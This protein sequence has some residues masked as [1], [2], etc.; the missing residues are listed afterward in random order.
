MVL[1]TFASLSLLLMA[2]AMVV[3]AVVL[4]ARKSASKHMHAYRLAIILPLGVVHLW[5]AA[6]WSF[7]LRDAGALYYGETGGLV[8]AVLASLTDA[9]LG[10]RHVAVLVVV[11]VG[12][13]ASLVAT[14]SR[15]RENVDHA[16]LAIACAWL[17]GADL[18]GR[19]VLGEC[20]DVLYPTDRTALQLVPVFLLLAATTID[21][22]GRKHRWVVW[23]A[24]VL[25]VLPTRT[26]LH[27]NLDRT[28]YW[29][30]QSIPDA[31]FRIADERQKALDRPLMMGGY[32]QMP[33]AWRLGNRI[34]RIDANELDVTDHP[35][36]SSDLLMI[37]TVLR[38]PPAGF[39][40][41]ARAATGRNNLLERV[42]PL[43]THIVFD[44]NFVLNCG[45]Q[46]FLDIWKPVTA[47][48]KGSEMFV[49][50]ES[51]IHEQGRFRAVLVLEVKD[52][53]GANLLYHK[54]ELCRGRDGWNGAI[55]RS[56]LRLPPVRHASDR[57]ALYIY[58][59]HH[60]TFRMEHG[61]L[62]IHA[63]LP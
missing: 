40:T 57:V 17:L 54:K 44:S 21:A 58:N 31:F 48:I 13:L 15:A 38:S 53:T 36:A 2:C 59:P 24:L 4:C 42:E 18:L 19:V 61:H 39:R 26:V 49:V 37:D 46:E 22:I 43:R 7:Y 32:H 10:S 33:A 30:E 20:F 51:V 14:W 60:D 29:P 12:L 28:V 47:A 1:A 50:V 23:S 55:L 3:G 62:R 8:N 41:I 25:L 6:K 63:V 35:H 56:A 34:R 52:S 9:I 11:I 45:G 5:F 16:M 27:A